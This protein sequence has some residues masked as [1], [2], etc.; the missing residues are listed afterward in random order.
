M[1]LSLPESAAALRARFGGAPWLW[2]R[3]AAVA[4]TN[5]QAV[6]LDTNRA[7]SGSLLPLARGAVR[8]Y[9]L[10]IVKEFPVVVTRLDSYAASADIASIDLLWI[11]VQ[12]AEALVLEG[13]G[14][15]LERTSAVMCEVSAYE[16]MYEG[17]ALFHELD[18]RLREAGLVLVMAGCDP[19]NGTGNALWIRPQSAEK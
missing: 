7:G 19:A 6:F 1:S 12:G 11:D 3:Q 10:A 8:D 14:E 18:A 13:A 2:I 17:A 16:P 15:L 9:G 4:D 5:G